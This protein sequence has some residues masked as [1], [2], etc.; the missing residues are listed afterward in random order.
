MDL[1]TSDL[2]S[3]LVCDVNG[4]SKAQFVKDLHVKVQENIQKRNGHYARVANKGRKEVIFNP[5]DWVWVHFQRIR[6]PDK[7]KS[8]LA[9]RGDGPFQIKNRVNNNAYVV[10][11]PG[12]YNVSSTFNVS[13]LSP[14]DVLGVDLDLRTNPLQEEG[15]DANPQVSHHL[16]NP[17][18]DIHRPTTRA[19]TKKMQ[20]ALSTFIR[21][22]SS[23]EESARVGDDRKL[24]MVLKA[25]WEEGTEATP[26][27]TCLLES[28][29]LQCATF[30]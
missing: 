28:S 11:L 22:I 4:A 23:S 24:K 21:G 13:D 20:E 3:S 18:K 6:F 29:A 2:P 16:I 14:F 9:P 8:K 15:D 1:A 17:T 19:M 30:V 27:R 7:V 12:E 26:V 25:S 10:D 5:G